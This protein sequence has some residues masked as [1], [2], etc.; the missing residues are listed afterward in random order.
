MDLGKLLENFVFLEYLKRNRDLFYYRGKREC[1]FLVT[2]EQNVEAA[3]Q[4]CW[5][6]TDA[7]REREVGGLLEALKELGLSTG[8]LVTDSQEETVEVGDKRIEIVP[9]WKWA[10]RL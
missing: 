9:A 6:L 5:E 7:N 8:W 1:D 3:V 10:V 2:S 4:V